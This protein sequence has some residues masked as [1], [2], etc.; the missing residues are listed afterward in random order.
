MSLTKENKKVLVTGGAGF[1]G[2]HVVDR[3]VSARA[4][5]F[6]AMSEEQ[7]TELAK[8]AEARARAKRR[9]QIPC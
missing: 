9:L 2:S 4:K 3:L 5:S 7:R 8:Q 1:V 6:R